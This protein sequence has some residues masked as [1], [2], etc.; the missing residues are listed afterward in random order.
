MEECQ[1]LAQR[2]LARLPIGKVDNWV[3]GGAQAMCNV[4]IVCWQAC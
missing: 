2:V 1:I 3:S 4:L